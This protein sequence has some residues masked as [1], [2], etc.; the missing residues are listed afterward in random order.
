M[1]RWNNQCLPSAAFRTG[2]SKCQRDQP[3]IHAQMALSSACTILARLS[4]G[5][6]VLL[7]IALF[8]VNSYNVMAGLRSVVLLPL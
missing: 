4:F 5:L 2:R 3:S 8:D 6:L 7:G 1:T